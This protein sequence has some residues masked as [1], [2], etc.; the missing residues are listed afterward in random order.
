[1]KKLL[2]EKKTAIVKEW[3][4]LVV[5]TYPADTSR[6][7]KSQKDPFANPVGRTTFSSLE[8]LFDEF[9]K[10][11]DLKA[12]ATQLDP[13]IRIRAVQDFSP[14]Q[15]TNFVFSLKKIIRTYLGK[16][17]NDLQRL[18][19][20]SKL[21]DRIDEI[22]LVAF[23]IYMKCRETIYQIKANQTHNRSYKAFERA[24]LITEIPE[25]KPDLEGH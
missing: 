5:E 18:G 23:D 1:L 17:I 14:S 13:I 11:N 8:A 7:L 2:A 25:N 9:V 22:G 16:E 24:G 4:N 15:A 20:L 12:V 6:F 19:E 21:E 3:F 10:E